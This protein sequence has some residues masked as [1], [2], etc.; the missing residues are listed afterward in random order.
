V[1][2]ASK[3]IVCVFV[4]CNWGKKN[5]DLSDKYKVEGYPTVVFC[6]PDGKQIA[7]LESRDPNGVA[8]QIESISKKYKGVFDSFEKAAAAAKDEKKP[9]LYLF[10]KPNVASSLAAAVGDASLKEI[11]EKFAVAQSD[12]V[13]GNADAKAFSISDPSL[14]VVDPEGEP[15][16]A[17]VYAKL[18]GKKEL[19]EVK[20]AL[21]DAL[22]KFQEG[23][24]KK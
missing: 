3:K 12:L 17:K 1:I 9:V 18:T 22:K 13:K 8:S 16:K 7:E 15:G 5:N 21:E 2:E 23:S 20:K 10:L 11:V 24:E 14:L 19:K 6:D 4:D